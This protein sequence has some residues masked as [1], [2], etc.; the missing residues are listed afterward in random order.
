MLDSIL[1]VHST[2]FVLYQD[3]NIMG[4]GTIILH[5]A[6]N[7]ADTGVNVGINISRCLVIIVRKK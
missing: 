3:I 5:Q 4:L 2:I 1:F 7:F 6:I